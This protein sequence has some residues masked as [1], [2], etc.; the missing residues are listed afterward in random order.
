MALAPAR[1]ALPDATG[2]FQDRAEAEYV[3]NLVTRLSQEINARTPDIS[4]RPNLLLQSP[5]GVVYSVA[6]DD[7][8]A[9]T[10]VKV[11]RSSR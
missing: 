1:I 8:G 6:V 5:G 7:A 9:L 4:A 2:V 10:T 11:E 3:A